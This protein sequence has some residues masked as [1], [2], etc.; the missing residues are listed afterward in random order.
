MDSGIAVAQRVYIDVCLFVW[1]H[2]KTFTLAPLGLIKLVRPNTTSAAETQHQHE[3]RSEYWRRWRRWHEQKGFTN[4]GRQLVSIL[5]HIYTLKQPWTRNSDI[6]CKFPDSRAK[7]G[8]RSFR[9]NNNNTQL[10]FRSIQMQKFS[11]D[12]PICVDFS[13]CL[14]FLFSQCLYVYMFCMFPTFQQNMFKVKI[15]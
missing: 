8:V 14:F 4:W 10:L 3:L 12:F 7:C 6:I 11:T 15:I 5:F 2:K 9:N 13:L 1:I